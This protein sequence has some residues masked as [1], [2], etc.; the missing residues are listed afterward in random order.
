MAGVLWSPIQIGLH[1]LILY[2]LQGKTAGAYGVQITV[3]F[4]LQHKISLKLLHKHSINQNIKH[5]LG[6][7]YQFSKITG[8]N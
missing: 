1:Q 4:L 5:Q 7:K 8:C 6:K 2:I 3:S